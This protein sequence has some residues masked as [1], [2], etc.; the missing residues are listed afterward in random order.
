[1]LV[2]DG[3]TQILQSY[4]SITRAESLTP[5]VK[6][7]PGETQPEYTKP[8]IPRMRP[9]G[10]WT[11]RRD[12]FPPIARLAG[13]WTYLLTNEHPP[14]I[15]PGPFTKELPAWTLARLARLGVPC[16]LVRPRHASGMATLLLQRMFPMWQFICYSRKNVISGH[17]GLPHYRFML[18]MVKR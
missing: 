2:I 17:S 12:C 8:R 9:P 5:S 6:R 3:S 16:P 14:R 1:M 15:S 18:A 11:R 10:E 7:L 13:D 4:E